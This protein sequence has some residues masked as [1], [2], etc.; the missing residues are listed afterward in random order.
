MFVQI[1]CGF[2]HGIGYEVLNSR[3]ADY[4]QILCLCRLY[5][6]FGYAHFMQ[7]VCSAY[8]VF[9][10]NFRQILSKIHAAEFMAKFMLNLI[11][12]CR[13]NLCYLCRTYAH[14]CK[15]WALYANS[16]SILCRDYVECYAAAD[17]LRGEDLCTVGG[18]SNCA[19]Y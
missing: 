3:F 1:I 10:L 18:N 8:A 5:A 16:M 11:Q 17:S 9:M 4:M 12:E 15:L 2:L 7:I 14:L 13:Q 19:F 6:D